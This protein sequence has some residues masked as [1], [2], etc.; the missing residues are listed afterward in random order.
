MRYKDKD[1]PYTI[2]SIGIDTDHPRYYVEFDDGEGIHHCQ[3]ITEEVFR[4]FDANELADIS[5]KNKCDRHFLKTIL[6]DAEIHNRSTES[7]DPL[8]EIIE[9]NEEKERLHRAILMLS[10]VQQRRILM[11]YFE[12]KTYKEI[13]EIEHCSIPAVKESL[14]SA[15]ERIVKFLWTMKSLPLIFPF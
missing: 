15:R 3:E 13:A 5:H 9:A 1:N 7:D 8:Q 14:E 2:Y 12:N 6:S 4:D 11:Y 10:S